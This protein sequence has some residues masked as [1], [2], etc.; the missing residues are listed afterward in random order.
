MEFGLAEDYAI[1]FL[2][3]LTKYPDRI[4][5][6]WEISEVMHIPKAFLAKI[7]QSL[8]IAGLI[9]I[10]RGKKGGYRLKKP[11]NKISLLDIIEGIKGKLIL[12]KCVENPQIC[13]RSSFCPV[14][15][16]WVE[17]NDNLR[18]A[19]K[20]QTIAELVKKERENIKK[21]AMSKKN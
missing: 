14:H 18:D 13:I 19:L 20:K 1:R 6:R 10:R 15:H 2:M 8:E 5:P 4:I 11:P 3:Y 12:T 21:L 9:E 7:A 16:F 17:L